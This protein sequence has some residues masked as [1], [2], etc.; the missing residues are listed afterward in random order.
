MA[1]FT[2]ITADKA[3]EVLGMSVVSGIINGSGHLIFTRGD[4]STI[5]A[6]DFTTIVS[7]ILSDTVEA[8]IAAQLPNYVAGIV[9]D[10]GNISGAVT[11][12]EFNSASLVNAMILMR[13]TGNITI[14][15]ASLPSSPKAGTQFAMKLQQD[16]TGSRTLTLTGFKKT[17][18]VLTLTT[19]PNAI[20]LLVFIFDGLT[21]YAGMMGADMQ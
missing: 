10:K 13:L 6:G 12:G 3:D 1:E 16:A 14:N 11:F 19:T 17:Q 20:D 4:G 18:G 15:T 9:A 8:S 2:G 21:W 7:D 5:D